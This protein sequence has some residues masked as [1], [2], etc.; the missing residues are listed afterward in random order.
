MNKIDQPH[1]ARAGTA[2]KATIRSRA[3]AP[4]GRT[5][6]TAR[7]V[8]SDEEAL[9]AAAAY[10]K[11]IAPGAI[12]RDHTGSVPEEELRELAAT[13]LLGI[14]VPRRL[15]GA[16]V[17][18]V[19]LAEVFRTI[20]VAD[21]AIAQI[22]QNHFFAVRILLQSGSPEQLEFFAAAV[23]RG[24]R[25]GNALSERGTTTAA[26]LRTRIT[27]TGD[28]EF[29]LDGRKYYATGALTAQWIPVYALDDQ[30]RRVAA[31]VER[32]A[33]GVEVVNDW[34]AM[35]Q[36]ATA[37]GTATFDGVRVPAERVVPHW[38]TFEV[39]QVFGAFGQIMHAAIDIGI[40][41]AALADAAEYVRT[42]SRL[43]FE[44]VQAGLDSVTAD[45]VTLV[46]FGQL[47]TRLHAAQALLRRAGGAIDVADALPAVTEEAAAA[48]S[49]AV[50]E[51]KA[52]GG[53]VAVEIANELFALAGTSAADQRHGL[54]R[55]WRNARTHTLHDPNVW[56][57]RHTGN[58]ILNGQ[59]PPNHELV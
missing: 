8:R 13:G 28:G 49:L 33:P 1:G 58:Y 39:P 43:S 3:Q 53:E 14:T 32:N 18:A 51:A 34:N 30:D 26:E 47:A 16:E 38:R 11:Q 21:P 50:G 15:G 55:H 27:P 45:P 40:A 25:F 37:S 36:R 12:E 6:I 29:R 41:E 52:F 35:G 4:T 10:A 5:T 17:S 54:D 31:F 57:Y 19:T 42:R 2:R 46:R 24:E 44:A 22:P 23:L 59:N 56:K 48:A 9:A 7:T 20:A